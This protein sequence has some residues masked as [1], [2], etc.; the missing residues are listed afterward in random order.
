MAN[1]H[2][3]DGDLGFS[4]WA[5]AAWIV[6]LLC[7]L[8]M[9]IL[10]ITRW[11]RK[12][13]PAPSPPITGASGASGSTGPPPFVVIVTGF[14]GPTG[15]SGLSGSTGVPSSVTGPTG[16][17]GLNI[18]VDQIGNLTDAVVTGIMLM[19]R[20]FGFGVTV[21]ERSSFTFPTGL[22]GNKTLHLLEW[23]P[24]V[25]PQWFDFGP[26]IGPSGLTGYPGPTGLNGVGIG[27]TGPTG[28]SPR[29]AT[30]NTG[31]QGVP[32][33]VGPFYGSLY[34][35]G[36]VSNPPPAEDLITITSNTTLTNDLYAR[37]LTVSAGTLFTNGFRI[38]VQNQFQVQSPG[39]ISNAGSPGANAAVNQVTPNTGGTG[40][41]AGQFIGGG[42]GGD[43]TNDGAFHEGGESP[44]ALF[45][46]GQA[47]G[48]LYA[49]GDNT[50]QSPTGGPGG[51]VVADNFFVRL[52]QFSSAIRPIH[53]M[54][55]L[56]ISGGSGGGSGASIQTT[57]TAASGGG[58]GGVIGLFVG[59]FLPSS[60]V[61]RANGGNGGNGITV[62]DSPGAGGGGG[63][64]IVRTTTPQSSILPSTFNINGGFGGAGNAGVSSN[65]KPGQVIFLSP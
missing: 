5:F 45:L 12:F 59:K 53:F 60:G 38:F 55:P 65:G 28:L 18:R 30:G 2:L 62:F 14:T 9:I 47:L 19:N 20:E 50:T 39:I 8:L 25:Q 1:G 21:D 54:P 15:F 52:Q 11:R 24:N 13:P 61:I 42:N 6:A 4:F 43:G 57:I 34:G 16:P 64:I 46:P 63:L 22:F 41:A 36:V 56:L 58:G 31:A 48:T 44:N 17:T 29:G 10:L 26:W 37:N 33:T 35:P 32:G 7:L 49:G 3:E 27:H 51:G 23:I 40:G